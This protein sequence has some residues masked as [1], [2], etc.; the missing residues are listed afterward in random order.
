MKS[1]L[2]EPSMELF[3]AIKNRRSIRSFHEE[4]IPSED[5]RR[6]L[7]AATEAPSAGNMQSWEFVIVRN[8][9]RKKVLVEGAFGQDFIAQAPVVIVVCA[10]TARSASRYRER[11]RSL[12]S[13]Q[14][15]AAAA[16]NILLTSHALGYGSCWIGA[17]D[18]SKI[19]QAINAP[20]EVRPVAIIPIGRPAES[21]EPRS[22]LSLERVVHQERFS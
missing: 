10:N 1:I 8:G 19:A 13:I 3:E 18:E 2:L 4:D 16:Q 17:F 15:T 20:S 22:R 7:E 21:P 9:D 11:G 14:D 12:Y 5:L 6:I